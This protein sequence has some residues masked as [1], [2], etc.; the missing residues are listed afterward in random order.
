[1]KEKHITTLKSSRYFLLG[2]LSHKTR[3]IWIL[4]H[5]YGQLA[6]EMLNSFKGFENDQRVFVAPE[7][8][9]RF[10]KKGFFGQVGAS[11]MT[12]ED[13]DSEIKD[14]LLFINNIYKQVSAEVN[15]VK[16]SINLFGFSQGA[17]A[18]FRVFADNKFKV[19]N[20][21]L[22]ASPPPSDVDLRKIR[23]LSAST[24][25]KVL[26]GRNDKLVDLSKMKEG[27]QP[28]LDNKVKFDLIEFDGGHEITESVLKTSIY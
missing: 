20:L 26:A 15:V 27:V 8:F 18:A 6:S 25:I 28:L 1:M 10:Y 12:K 4:F 11:W 16:S 17:A 24:S 14:Y 23:I 22:F 3:D 5:G 13:R 7:G 9:S 2:E 19:D 21:V